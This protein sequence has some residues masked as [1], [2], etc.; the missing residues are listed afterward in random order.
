MSERE[1]RLHIYREAIDSEQWRS[2]LVEELLQVSTFE[3]R[4]IDQ[5]TM[6]ARVPEAVVVHHTEL[7]KLHRSIGRKV[8]ESSLEEL[9]VHIVE[10]LP[11][12]HKE[13][14]EVPTLPAIVHRY[15]DDTRRRMLTIGGHPRVVEERAAALC[16]IRAF[17]GLF[18]FPADT[19][20]IADYVT[21]IS[22]ARSD[23][24]E[25]AR[26]VEYLA[27][28]IRKKDLLPEAVRLQAVDFDIT[29]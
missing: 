20:V 4:T 13:D 6:P 5:I 15:T 7:S 25:K 27:A 19:I 1:P 12:S 26:I 17:Y 3:S 8:T 24:G 9:K 16:A 2:L 21:A 28:A 29:T 22:L 23:K 18:C 11:K 10:A 14:I